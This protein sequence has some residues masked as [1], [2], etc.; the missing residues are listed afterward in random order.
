MV[1]G[2]NLRRL[3]NNMMAFE[4]FK[5]ETDK[6]S[7]LTEVARKIPCIISSAAVFQGVFNVVR[8]KNCS[9]EYLNDRLI[10]FGTDVLLNDNL[11]DHNN[12]YRSLNYQK[13]F[14]NKHH[15]FD[16]LKTFVSLLST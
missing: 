5:P 11:N 8:R 12:F 6:F 2:S 14:I 13:S 7:R 15:C 16:A 1:L 4:F 3:Y 9:N 10:L